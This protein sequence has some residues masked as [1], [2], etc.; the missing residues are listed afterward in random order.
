MND[1]Y[2]KVIFIII[3]II[4]RMDVPYVYNGFIVFQKQ[5]NNN[6]ILYHLFG[7]NGTHKV[8]D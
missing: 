7:T 5:L 8:D 2:N 1:I 6:L 4:I 3:I